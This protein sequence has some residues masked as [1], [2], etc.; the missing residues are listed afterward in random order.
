MKLIFKQ[1]FWGSQA[2]K[3]AESDFWG[4]LIVIV[5]KYQPQRT[6]TSEELRCPWFHSCRTYKRVPPQM[7]CGAR[8]S[9]S[10][11]APGK[12][13]FLFLCRGEKKKTGGNENP[14]KKRKK[15]RRALS[16]S[17]SFF[18]FQ[19]REFDLANQ[20]WGSRNRSGERRHSVFLPRRC[21]PLRCRADAAAGFT[22]FRA[23][24]VLGSCPAAF[25]MPPLSLWLSR[26]FT[27]HAGCMERHTWFRRTRLFSRCGAIVCAC[28]LMILV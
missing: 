17:A 3:K 7:T 5:H 23:Y 20:G 19:C 11:S 4:I 21:S 9:V 1:S 6:G 27:F 16:L 26:L 14:R 22:F 24:C 18:V 2:Q 10:T 8:V 15:K 25:S 12:R 13:P 28:P